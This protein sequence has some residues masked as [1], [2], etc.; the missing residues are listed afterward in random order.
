MTKY[1]DLFPE[2]YTKARHNAQTK[3][4]RLS[5]TPSKKAKEWE[6]ATYAE[7][8]LAARGQE[9]EWGCWADR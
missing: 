8:G 5:K 6:R 9:Q 1:P 4:I 7:R 3:Q 2:P